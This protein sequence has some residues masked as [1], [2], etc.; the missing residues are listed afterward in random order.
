MMNFSEALELAKNGRRITRKGWNG[1]DQYVKLL[2]PL[3]LSYEALQL[4]KF[5]VQFGPFLAIK[6]SYGNVVPWVASQTDLLANDW[7]EVK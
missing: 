6:T 5:Q 3:E 7:E 1:K 2:Q 4:D